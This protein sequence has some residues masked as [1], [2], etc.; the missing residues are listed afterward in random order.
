MS[1]GGLHGLML[2]FGVAWAQSHDYML[3]KVS[4]FASCETPLTENAHS[5]LK[6]PL[7]LQQAGTCAG[8][9]MPHRQ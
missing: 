4:I 7:I 1:A 9:Q 3:I 2:R 8:T 6:Q 5:K